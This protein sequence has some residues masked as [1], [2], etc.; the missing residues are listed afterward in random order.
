MGFYK[1][2]IFIFIFNIAFAFDIEV[3]YGV[4]NNKR[5]SIVTLKHHKRFPCKENR[6]INNKNIMIECVVDGT[7]IS[8][9][10]R[11]KT[12]F[13][14]IYSKINGNKFYLFI[15]PLKEQSLFATFLDLKS[16]IPIPV[17]RPKT[18]KIWQIIGYDSEM[19]FLSNKTYRGI[20]FP[21]SIANFS[22]PSIKELNIDASPLT[23]D[24][25]PDL[26]LFLNIRSTYD[27]KKYQEVIRLAD[28]MLNEYPNSLFK[29][30]ILLYKIKSMHSINYTSDDVLQLAKEWLR[31]YPADIGVPEVLFIVADS[32]SKMKIYNEARYYF[33]RII[34]EYQSS[35]YAQ[36]ALV[37]IAK[38]L[39][40][41]GDKKR[42]E[43][44]YAQAYEES[45]DLDTAS[46]VIYNWGNFE[47]ENEDINN[48]AILFSRII[49]SNPKYFLNDLDSS[50]KDFHKWADLK[51]YGIAAKAGNGILNYLSNDEFKE[52]L[53]IDVS[54]WYE[55]DSK[56]QDAHRINSEFLNLFKDSINA[57]LIKQR[58]D[59]L[60]FH[61]NEGDLEKQIEQ[62]NYIITTYPNTPQSSMAYE[63]KAKALFDMGLYKDVL[64]L[65]ANLK[66]DD[67]NIKKSYIKIIEDSKSCK[68]I[69]DYYL[70]QNDI[71]L[72][73]NANRVFGCLFESSLFNQ[74]KDLSNLVLS[75]SLNSKD[76]LIWLYNASRSFFALQDYN[77]AAHSSRDAFNIA[78]ELGEYQDSGIVLFLSLANLNR[79]N[80]AIALFDELSRLFSNS[81]EMLD[82]YY[83]MLKWSIE[84]NDNIAIE[85]Y[86]KD[87]IK[88]QNS[89]KMYEY[90]PFVELTYADVL[91]S[92]YRYTQMLDILK[93]IESIELSDD[94][95][96]KV[97]YLR[98]VAYSELGESA[99]AKIEFDK[100]LDINARDS[101]GRLCS[102]ALDLLN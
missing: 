15:K 22:L 5:F 94:E 9:F 48:A 95:L 25:G 54:L 41:N 61:L 1:F 75:G 58:D 8:S 71:L 82:V 11:S 46:Y 97:Y 92:D 18:S 12:E 42:L 70:E 30:D 74:A 33:D 63:K 31:A 88:L 64:A 69:L 4:E 24:I 16:D 53:M 45:K 81:K 89:L 32:Y 56:I 38:N 29:R 90:S 55:L 68:E 101:F 59:N 10:P 65:K 23:Y 84:S 14:E 86:A 47:L 52:R 98:G 13:F 100:C 51:L 83:Y 3:D 37:G 76:K 93:N 102:D 36:Y 20:N 60:L 66:S 67:E 43:A 50:Y 6:D 80:E 79:K 78:K 57:A 40:K 44:L 2:F 35:K 17:E 28:E 34:D 26:N 19:P 27:N 73:S 99:N 77:N 62:Y 39:A 49:N 87:L 96:Q 85:R 7:P 72:T 21:I 91:F